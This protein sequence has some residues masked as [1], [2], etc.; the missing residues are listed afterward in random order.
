MKKAIV[1]AFAA[2]VTLGACAKSQSKSE[3]PSV[4]ERVTDMPQRVLPD[5]LPLAPS[6]VLKDI[7][8]N[9]VSLSD[10]RGKWVVLDFWGSWCG[11]CIKGIPALKH[12]YE[13]NKDKLVVIGIDCGDTQEQ[14]RAA[15]S[16]YKLPWINVYNPVSDTS[17]EVRYQV[18][19]YPTKVIITPDGKIAASVPGEN[20]EFYSLLDHLMNR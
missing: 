8:G 16:H 3:K 13:T 5:E 9:D 7:A 20:P 17:V 12:Y 11:W 6:F 2:L 10:F 19:G 4:S 14:W 18:Q 15:V 1:F